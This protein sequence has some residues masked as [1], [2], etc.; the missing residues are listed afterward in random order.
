[1]VARRIVKLNH[2]SQSLETIPV[3]ILIYII[4]TCSFSVIAPQ[5]VVPT[6]FKL[7]Q[8]RYLPRQI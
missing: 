4:I 8:I 1:M 6:M 2:A 7:Y 3:S 5:P